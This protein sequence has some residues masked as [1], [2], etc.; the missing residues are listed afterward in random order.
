LKIQRAEEEAE[1]TRE[2]EEDPTVAAVLKQFPGSKIV[3]ISFQEEE[4]I[5]EAVPEDDDL[6]NNGE[7]P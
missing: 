3:N 4:E 2:A 5:L 1:R 6:D 7:T